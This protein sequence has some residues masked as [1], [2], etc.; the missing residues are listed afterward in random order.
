VIKDGNRS[1]RASKKKK[2]EKKKK[3]LNISFFGRF[4]SK[5]FLFGLFLVQYNYAFLIFI[6][7]SD[8][9]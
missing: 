4:W 9:L 8:V 2:K 3:Q 1:D 5:I 6:C 7:S